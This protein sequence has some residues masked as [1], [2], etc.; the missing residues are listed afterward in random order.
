MRFGRNR[1]LSLITLCVIAP[2]LAL[3]QPEVKFTC[4]PNHFPAQPDNQLLGPV[5]G[6]AAIDRAGNVYVSTDTPRGILVFGPAANALSPRQR[7]MEP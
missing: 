4:V 7:H 5:H 2:L 1:F 6:G 3:P